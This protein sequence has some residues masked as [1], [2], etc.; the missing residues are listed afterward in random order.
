M[1]EKK[2][3]VEVVELNEKKQLAL[4]NSDLEGLLNCDGLANLR[5]NKDLPIIFSFRLADLLGKL[6]PTI[7]AYSDQKQKLIEK[8][9]D[10]DKEGKLVEQRP[11]M[12]VFS[13]KAQWF[14]KEFTEL[15]DIEISV[16]GPKLEIKKEDIPKGTI[17]AD[18]IISLMAIIDFK[19]E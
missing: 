17:S 16:D 6:Q 3:K 1:N 5:K 15:L 4:K 14:Q 18:D 19:E 12:F 2:E 8:Y 7:K 9:A 13:T 10:R 11:N